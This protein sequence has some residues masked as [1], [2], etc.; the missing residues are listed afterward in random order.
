MQYGKRSVNKNDISEM[1]IKKMISSVSLV[2]LLFGIV[3]NTHIAI[4]DH[5]IKE[6][7]LSKFVEGQSVFGEKL[8]CTALLGLEMPEMVLVKQECLIEI[9]GNVSGSDVKSVLEDSGDFSDID[10]IC[11]KGVKCKCALPKENETKMLGCDFSW[12]TNCVEKE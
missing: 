10:K 1:K 11:I 5:G 6:A 7:S 3:I 12:E 9:F 4:N 2:S 8:L